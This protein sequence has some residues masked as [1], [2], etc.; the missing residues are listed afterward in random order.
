MRTSALRDNK[1]CNIKQIINCFF[2][3]KL[4]FFYVTV[5]PNLK[6]PTFSQR[7]KA[8]VATHILMHLNQ[9]PAD[10]LTTWRAFFRY[11]VS[12]LLARAGTSNTKDNALSRP[13]HSRR[14]TNRRFLTVRRKCENVNGNKTESV[15]KS[16]FETT[17]RARCA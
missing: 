15:L 14:K 11:G 6:D 8:T 10:P 1:L 2:T 4:L 16:D 7:T 3:L 12:R 13:C 5:L 17:S 9:N